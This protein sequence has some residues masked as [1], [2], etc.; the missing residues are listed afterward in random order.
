LNL[1]YWYT[2]LYSASYPRSI[3]MCFHT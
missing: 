3:L 1:T 2:H